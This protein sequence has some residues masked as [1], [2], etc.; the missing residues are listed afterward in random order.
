MKTRDFASKY[1][2][3]DKT[4]PVTGPFRLPMYPFL[5][6]PL[7][8]SD[9]IRIK[10]LV[11]YKAS[12]CLGTVL[13]QIINAKR[14]AL[15]VGD[16]IMVCQTDDDA[17]KWT[18]T[19][20][21]EWLE[22]IP[23][24]VRLIK[25]DKYAQTNDLWLFRHKFLKISG[26]GITAAQS[27]QVRYVQTDESHLEAFPPGRLA[28]FEKRMGARWDRQATHITTAANEGKE[29]DQFYYQ[30]SQE[31]WHWRCQSCSEL[32]LPLWTERAKVKYNGQQ[33]FIWK[34]LQSETATLES[35][36]A[37]CPHCGAE[38]H[39]TSR[40]R[41]SL[42][43]DADYVSMNP[44]APVEFASFQWA[45]FAAAHWMPFHEFLSEHLLAMK[46]AKEMS[47]LKPHED[48]VKKRECRS[49]RPE[50]PD[51]GD[52]K[53]AND[54]AIGDKWEVEDTVTILSADYQA[55]KKAE[56]S[57]LWALVTQWDRQGNSRRLDF[58]RL[59]TWAQLRAMQLEFGVL[60]S[61]VFVDCGYDDRTVFYQC[62]L[63]R[64]Y[65]TKGS[66]LQQY[67]TITVDPKLPRVTVPMPYSQ[68]ERQ[69]GNVGTR[70]PD[71]LKSSLRGSLPAGWCLSR[72]MGNPQLY[73]ILYA[74]Q[75]GS[76]GRYFGIAKDMPKEYIEGFPA[77]MPVVEKNKRT[78]LE[79]IIWK[80]IKT[81][82]HPWDC[83]VQALMGAMV[84]GYY[85]LKELTET[86][87]EEKEA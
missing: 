38:Y 53:G 54:Y 87:P 81:V 5:S 56:G 25:N 74:L 48:F 19:R 58:R 24:V 86:Q 40:E 83:E 26:P 65:A 12:S 50:L 27:D 3:F 35:I 62:S 64:W 28:E 59:D 60:D 32:I 43:R 84:A 69:N 70:Q 39:D 47:D 80:K 22:S 9:D 78:N 76:A 10:R 33:V 55:G 68:T 37:K 63:Y 66:D 52:A 16:Q 23:I 30:G 1:I 42:Q 31:E 57:H 61:N 85:P 11:I 46:S 7:D 45:A 75:S 73:G 36:F 79:S 71:R 17:T 67:H 14:I 15:D 13:G 51:Y 44:Q 34:D 77:F 6:K 8:A 49:Y 20:G 41:F 29:I 18:K 82:D 21:K 4:S 72:T 2:R